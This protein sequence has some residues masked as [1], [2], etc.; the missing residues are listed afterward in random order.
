[1]PE[2][3]QSL[4]CSYCLFQRI[5]TM[6]LPYPLQS[7]VNPLQRL[8]G[9]L[10]SGIDWH[11]HIA[12]RKEVYAQHPD[13]VLPRY[14]LAPEIR[15]LAKLPI[16]AQHRML[17]LLLF[18]T[19]AR[20]NEL[21]DLTPER[22]KTFHQSGNRFTTITLRTLKQQR[23]EGSGKAPKDAFRVVVLYD[24]AFADELNSY[25]VTFCRNKKHPIFRSET[26]QNRHTRSRSI[27]DQTARNWLAIIDQEAKKAGINLLIPLTPKVLRHSCAIHLLLHGFP[28]Q[29]IQKQLGH[30]HLKNTSIY[31]DLLLLDTDLSINIK[32]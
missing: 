21:L 28:L 20:I 30:C 29:R 6:N 17:L 11:Y 7:A 26:K 19:G 15:Q 31:T 27:T 2:S 32:F 10:S 12:F 24:K 4:K 5:V 18:N 3:V 22:V 16:H 1:M 13:I 14:L 9:E 8:S 23:R 25:I